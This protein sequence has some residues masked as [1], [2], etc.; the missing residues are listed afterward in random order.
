[1]SRNPRERVGTLL[2]RFTVPRRDSANF[3]AADFRFGLQVSNGMDDPLEVSVRV[4][5]PPRRRK[6]GTP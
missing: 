4:L 5:R 1:M 3:R 2:V 6:E